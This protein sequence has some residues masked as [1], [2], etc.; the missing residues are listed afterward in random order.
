MIGIYKITNLLNN[1]SYI[2]QSVHI[3]RRWQE[4]CNPNNKSQIAQAI[5]RYGKENFRFEVLE[6][7]AKTDLNKRENYWI[8]FYNTLA[9]NGYNIQDNTNSVHSSYRV[10]S[11]STLLQII[12]TLQQSN[13]TLKEIANDYNVSI[14]TISR[15]NA[16]FIHHQDNISYP[17][18]T[19]NWSPHISK[20]CI[21]CGI[22]ISD[23]AT[24]CNKCEGKHRCIELPIS[25]DELKAKIR[26]QS[27]VQIGKDFN[28]T[29]NA[30]RKW[31]IKYNLPKTKKEINSYS[32][33]E[34]ED[35]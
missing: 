8:E 32:D 13:K 22:K 33:E 23:T 16:G 28:V 1:K 30:I 2:G 19:T 10:F 11:K 12:A 9:P 20:Y 5:Q 17:I 4:H 7:C 34:W 29:D 31:C 6:E 18:R 25:R 35:K 14:S 26:H 21:D 15:I 3:H 24:R 27:F